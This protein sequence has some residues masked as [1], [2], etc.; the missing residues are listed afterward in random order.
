MR[1]STGAVFDLQGETDRDDEEAGPFVLNL[2]S[3]PGHLSIPQPRA[4]GLSRYAF[5]V[6]RGTEGNREQCWLHMGYFAS[7]S[8]AEKWL[9]I[10]HRVYPLA[11]VTPAPLTFVPQDA[12]V[13]H[14]VAIRLEST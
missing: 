6:S 1:F 11:F 7:R 14:G 5:F 3:V 13:E 12:A 9:E 10:L 8:E 2:C 4:P